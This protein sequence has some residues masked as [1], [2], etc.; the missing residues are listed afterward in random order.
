MKKKID[1]FKRKLHSLIERIKLSESDYLS[2][3]SK[4]QMYSDMMS[5]IKYECNTD[6][7][8]I[9]SNGQTIARFPRSKTMTL[10]IDVEQMLE[11]GGI[12]FDKNA[13]KLNAK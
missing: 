3:K 11:N 4:A 2:M 1:V 12:T 5:A 8:D 13:V 6:Y 9:K 7:E 10:N